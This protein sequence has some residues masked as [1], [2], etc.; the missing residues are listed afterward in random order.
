MGDLFVA[1]VLEQGALDR[2]VD[3]PSG[4]AW[5]DFWSGAPAESGRYDVPLDSIAV[6]APRGAIIPMYTDAPDTLRDGPLSGLV[7]RDE[8]DTAR[9][10]TIFGSGSVDADFRFTEADGTR[11]EVTGSCTGPGTTAFSTANGSFDVNG[12]HIRILSPV[13]RVYTVIVR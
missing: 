1:P 5:F 13:E 8:V 3:L 12:L 10:V 9:T 6:Y 7:T 2:Q 11:Y 4:A